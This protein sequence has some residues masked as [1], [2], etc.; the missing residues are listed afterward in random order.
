M[1][2]N[3]NV[4]FVIDMQNDF[5]ADR[6]CFELA[7]YVY[8]FTPDITSNLKDYKQKPPVLA[9]YATDL[10]YVKNVADFISSSN[11]TYIYASHDFH[12]DNHCSFKAFPKHCVQGTIGWLPHPLI[13]GALSDIE[14]K[15]TQPRGEVVRTYKG[16]DQTCDSYAAFHDPDCTTKEQKRNKDSANIMCRN[17]VLA[18]DIDQK[19]NNPDNKHKVGTLKTSCEP[20]SGE[21]AKLKTGAFRNDNIMKESTPLLINYCGD[22]NKFNYDDNVANVSNESRENLGNTTISDRCTFHKIKYADFNSNDTVTV[23]GLCTDFCAANTAINLKQEYSD[24][25]VIFRIDLTRPIGF[26][27]LH[28]LYNDNTSGPIYKQYIEYFE[29]NDITDGSTEQSRTIGGK[30]I[31]DYMN[32]RIAVYCII[33]KYYGVKIM[34][35]D[36]E[37]TIKPY[38]RNKE[39]KLEILNMPQLKHKL[40]SEGK[41]VFTFDGTETYSVDTNETKFVPLEITNGYIM[42]NPPES[43]GN[44]KEHIKKK[45]ESL[46]DL[47]VRLMSPTYTNIKIDTIFYNVLNKIESNDTQQ[48]GGGVRSKRNNQRYRRLPFKHSPP[49]PQYAL[50]AGSLSAMMASAASKASPSKHLRGSGNHINKNKTITKK[51]PGGGNAHSQKKPRRTTPSLISIGKMTFMAGGKQVTRTVYRKNVGSGG[52]GGNV[53]TYYKKK[54]P[55]TNKFEYKQ[56]R[57]S[58]QTA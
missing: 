26:D 21:N 14:K 42:G 13:H 45:K 34:N 31:C 46:Q 20:L 11:W 37:V 39:K 57:K 15:Q 54:N 58:M 19:T 53:A 16:F 5:I 56:V 18:P 2:N 28:T 55:T 3:E 49:L 30:K 35:G 7:N 47:F 24:A 33:M 22:V 29:T 23:C 50:S 25:N 48:I 4:L 17:Q 8:N 27:Y 9:A 43:G 1:G 41:D 10:Q 52:N 40:N 51:A 6:E 12:P 32:A 38:R 36:K 44:V